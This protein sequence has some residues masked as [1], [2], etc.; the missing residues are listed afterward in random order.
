MVRF[1]GAARG[2]FSTPAKAATEV[3]WGR[4]VIRGLYS[5][6]GGMQATSAQQDVTA[7]NLA[8]A[9]KPGYRRE[10][11]QF[12]AVGQHDEMLGPTASVHSDFAPGTLEFSGNRLDVALNGPGFFTVQG[13]QGPLYTRNGVFQLS[14]QGEL[15]TMEGLLA[16][17]ASGP[18]IVPPGTAT[19]EILGDGTVIADG[20]EIDRL[21]LVAFQNPHEMQ[22]V[23]TSYF[24]APA[25]AATL[26]TEL[27]EVRQGYRE[28]S[29]TSVVHEMVQMVAG[30]RQFE[31]A[32]RALRSL[33]DTLALTTR[34]LNR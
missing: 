6:A 29:N 9:V 34:P 11:L 8:H 17:G 26:P 7:H 21:R 19:I 13:S 27:L 33:G 1:G 12:E 10:I 18:I 20:A 25:S 30:L 28:G 15:V 3:R 2:A 16:Q 32:Q 4:A 23:G 31:A 24:V 22:R 14:S 5:A